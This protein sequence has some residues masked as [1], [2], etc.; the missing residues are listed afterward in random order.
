MHADPVEYKT[1]TIMPLASLSMPGYAATALV[2]RQGGKQQASA[3][4]A[5]SHQRKL[6]VSLRLNTRKLTSTVGDARNHHSPF[7]DSWLA[8]RV[9]ETTATSQA[10]ARSDHVDRIISSPLLRRRPLLLASIFGG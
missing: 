9:V 6:P 1:S 2:T 5:I 4:S 8:D 3:S 7:A 10:I